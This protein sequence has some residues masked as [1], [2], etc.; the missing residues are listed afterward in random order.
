MIDFVLEVADAPAVPNHLAAED[1]VGAL[2][3]VDVVPL[4][5]VVVDHVIEHA[6][7]I[8]LLDWDPVLRS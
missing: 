7:G 4:D 1:Q 3:V 6:H 5:P 8:L 2:Q